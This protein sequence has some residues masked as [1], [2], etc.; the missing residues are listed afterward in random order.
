MKNN[1]LYPQISQITQIKEFVEL[2]ALSQ[3]SGQQ[4]TQFINY[5][6]AIGL[7]TELLLNFLEYKRF[8]FNL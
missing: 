2:K 1:K 4:K 3:F 8:V 6:K 5:L 7:K